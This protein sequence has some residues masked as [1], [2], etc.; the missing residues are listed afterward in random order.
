SSCR[1]SLQR[2][3]AAATF[4]ST[5]TAPARLA[6]NVTLSWRGRGNGTIL[7]EEN[8]RNRCDK[9]GAILV[10]APSRR[11]ARCCRFAYQSSRPSIRGADSRRF[12][13][14]RAPREASIAARDRLWHAGR[15]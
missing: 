10:G 2:S 1:G 9:D 4:T 6:E 13:T 5:T 11:L 7:L 12:V 3:W 8:S 14:R 15:G